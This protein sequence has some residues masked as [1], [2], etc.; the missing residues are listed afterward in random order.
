[1]KKFFFSPALSH[2]RANCIWVATRSRAAA[3]AAAAAA[4]QKHCPISTDE[5]ERF[6][7]FLFSRL[8]GAA[9]HEIEILFFI[10]SLF[11][12]AD[13]LLC[14]VVRFVCVCLCAIVYAFNITYVFHSPLTRPS[15]GQFII[16]IIWDIMYLHGVHWIYWNGACSKVKGRRK[17]D[18]QWQVLWEEKDWIIRNNIKH[19]AMQKFQKKTKRKKNRPKIRNGSSRSTGGAT[20]GIHKD[21]W[22]LGTRHTFIYDVLVFNR[23][24]NYFYDYSSSAHTRTWNVCVFVISPLE[25]T[26]PQGTSI[27]IKNNKKN[28]KK[29]EPKTHIEQ[30]DPTEFN[31]FSMLSYY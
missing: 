16:I 8:S 19:F 31:G 18:S 13:S 7:L 2:H 21:V 9:F 11:P 14:S 27:S 22:P 4:A 29:R 24:M 28:K 15:F 23:W 1:M 5:G 3:A 30:Y 25:S 12:L 6:F 10:I 17:T 26:T 20:D